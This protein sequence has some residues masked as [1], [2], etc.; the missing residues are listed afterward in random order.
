MGLHV[1]S[2]R[3]Y[4]DIGKLGLGGGRRDGFGFG[5]GQTY[6]RVQRKL[7]LRNHNI[8]LEWQPIFIRIRPEFILGVTRRRDPLVLLKIFLVFPHGLFHDHRGVGFGSLLPIFE[9]SHRWCGSSI[10]PKVGF[11]K[12]LAIGGW[13]ICKKRIA[14]GDCCFVDGSLLKFLGVMV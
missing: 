7:R 5:E 14:I 13:V 4:S 3:W 9:V 6:R 10:E 2:H 11:C 1:G 8:I 12:S